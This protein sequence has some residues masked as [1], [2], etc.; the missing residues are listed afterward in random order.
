MGT[1]GLDGGLI[2]GRT[3]VTGASVGLPFVGSPI[4]VGP[5]SSWPGFVSVQDG[6]LSSDW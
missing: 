1:P 6:A 4:D 3:I 2:G 5:S